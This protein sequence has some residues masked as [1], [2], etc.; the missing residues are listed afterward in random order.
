M[1]QSPKPAHEP[2]TAETL[3]D[4][5]SAERSASAAQR[6][7]DA[8]ERAST[9]AERAAVAAERVADAALKTLAVAQESLDLVRA[10]VAEARSAAAASSAESVD[11]AGEATAAQALEDASRDRYHARA[12]KPG[13]ARVGDVAGTDPA[14]RLDMSAVGDDGQVFGG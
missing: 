11:M 6:A 7:A 3:E 10:S 8:A 1:P 13:S 5:R 14:D 4:W 9:A 2:T 12:A